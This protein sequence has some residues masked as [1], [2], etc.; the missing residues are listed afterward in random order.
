MFYID[1]YYYYFIPNHISGHWSLLRDIEVSILSNS[2][3]SL[4]SIRFNYFDKSCYLSYY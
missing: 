3:V 4:I 1:G 2:R